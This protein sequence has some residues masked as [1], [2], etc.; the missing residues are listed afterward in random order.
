MKQNLFNKLWLR[1][2]M[3]V[4]IMT[5]AL[6]GTAWA[7]SKTI[8]AGALTDG[9]L[10]E[11]PFTLT[12]AKNNG[13]TAPTYNA[14]G[15]DIRLY[16]KG[17]VTVA[18]SG[19]NMT[20][21]VFNLSAQGKKRLAPITASV[22]TIATQSSGDETVTWTG[23]AASVT[24][25]VGDN[26]TYGSENT[27]AGQLCFSSVDITYTA[28]GTPTCATPTFSPAAGTYAEA[29]SVTISTTTSDATIYYTTDGST[30]SNAS[31]Q[32]T[33]AI[34]VS[35]TT[36]IKAIAVKEGMNNSTVAT[37]TYIIEAPFVVQDGIFDFNASNYGSGY[38]TSGVQV[39]SG[40]WTAVNVTMTTAGRNCWFLEQDNS[41]TLRLYKT[42]NSDAGGSMKFV[43]PAGYTITKIEFEGKN[44]SQI[45]ESVG[46]Y[47]YAEDKKSG[48]WTGSTN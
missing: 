8:N 19:G 21:I 9:V 17:T 23:D 10:A 6:S 25:T 46:S 40:T 2:G 27:K 1:V 4:A 35:T 11:S 3:I 22:G 28:S 24:F 16:A 44:V 48:T 26:A 33:G 45:S 37:A 34:P 36:T 32:Y 30:P 13:S 39:Q 14:N 5:T 43:V 38:E 31:T 15:G 20:T 12:F 7:E 29:Q 18:L 42:L 47:E 41:K